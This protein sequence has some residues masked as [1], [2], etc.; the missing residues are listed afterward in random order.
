MQGRKVPYFS[1]EIVGLRR[2]KKVSGTDIYV[3][4]N[5]SANQIRN[6]VEKM[7]RKYDIKIN[8]YKVY[9]RADYTSMPR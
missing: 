4:T 7:L 3:M 6:V 1:K 2:P 9:L 8:D 5:M